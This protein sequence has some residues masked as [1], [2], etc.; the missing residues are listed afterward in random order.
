MGNATMTSMAG[1]AVPVGQGTPIGRR[2]AWIFVAALAVAAAVSGGALS[3]RA[4]NTRTDRGPFAVNETVPTAFGAVAVEAA[5]TLGG[6]TQR[7]LSSVT[8][9]INALVKPDEMQVETTVTVTNLSK[10]LAHYSPAEF[11]LAV[12]AH[13]AVYDVARSS[14][15]EGTLQ[16]DSNIELRLIY[17]AKLSAGDL[18]LRYAEPGKGA[19]VFS[20]GHGSGEPQV[21]HGE[22]TV[23]VLPSDLQD[24]NH[25]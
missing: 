13:G 15:G 22:P 4:M 19:V 24:H 2:A 14:V 3:V 23:P 11:R 10:H 8:H 7:A 25:R 21:A 17:V 9:G 5:S 20:I 6:P 12:G 16:P 18:F 1:R